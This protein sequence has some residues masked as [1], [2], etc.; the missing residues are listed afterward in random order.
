MGGSASLRQRFEAE[1]YQ[2]KNLCSTNLLYAPWHLYEVRYL[3]WSGSNHRDVAQITEVLLQTGIKLRFV[4]QFSLAVLQLD[5]AGGYYW[6]GGSGW[7]RIV[8][9]FHR[10]HLIKTNT[11]KKK[12]AYVHAG[13]VWA[14]WTLFVDR[15]C[16]CVC[17]CVCVLVCVSCSNLV[18]IWNKRRCWN[19]ILG[20]LCSS[21]LSSN[22]PRCQSSMWL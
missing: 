11:I 16:V 14:A 19:V 4:N 12:K 17:V 8:N 3:F 1:C 7:A 20:R 21:V 22:L 10:S 13:C 18:G 6:R 5:Q 2:R 9:T 15:W